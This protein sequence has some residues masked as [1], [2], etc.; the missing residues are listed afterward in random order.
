MEKY[1]SGMKNEM[2]QQVK[3]Q[4]VLELNSEHH[5]FQSLKAAYGEDKDKAGKLA[6]ILLDQ[7]KLI[8]G[9]P[10]EDAAQYT[11]LVCEL[12]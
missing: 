8:A 1:F 3:A 12:F 11:E 2:A 4:R 9:L 7:G 10:L 5:A 6:R